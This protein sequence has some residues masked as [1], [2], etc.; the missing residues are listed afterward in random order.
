MVCK[1][2]FPFNR[3]L[4]F[5]TL[6]SFSSQS[7]AQS[8]WND[9]VT[10]MTLVG[11]PGGVPSCSPV[12]WRVDPDTP[13]A[14][15]GVE[16][17]DRVLQI[18]EHKN[19][20]IR[21]VSTLLHTPTYQINR[22]RMIGK[23]GEY[24]VEVGR[25]RASEIFQR[26]GMKL[27]PNGMIFPVD[28]SEAE[29]E[30]ISKIESE[31]PKEEKA[32][33]VGHYPADLSVYYP[34]FELW[35]GTVGKPVTVGGIEDGP[36]KHA[37]VHYGDTILRVNGIDPKGKSIPDVERLFSSTEAT[38][39]TVLIERDGDHRTISF[40]LE[41]ASDIAAKNMKQQYQGRMI[42]SVIAPGDLHCWDSSK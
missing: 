14:K 33:N 27:G 26:Q 5:I 24:S 34:G 15:A 29:M 25:I 20:D 10:G 35:V 6:F 16:P 13:A 28:A 19:P 38:K 40:D 11:R 31:P 17:G 36:A 18:D 23:R 30:R 42:P 7:S 1:R 9:Y 2:A 12:V 3:L 39:I 4:L 37:G 21:E 41:R 22:L 8:G 32:F